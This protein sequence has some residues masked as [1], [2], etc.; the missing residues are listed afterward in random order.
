MT[1]V[2]MQAAEFATIEVAE[3][4]EAALAELIARY[5]EFEATDPGPWSEERVPAPLLAF[6]AKH[7]IEWPGTDSSRFLLKGIFEE[8][9]TLLR[10]DRMV[11]FFG[12]GFELGGKTLRSILR[13]LGAVGVGYDG[14]CDL[15]VQAKDPA[16]RAAE[17]AEFLVD[18]DYEEQF[19][20]AADPLPSRLFSVTLE[21]NGERSA[22]TFN[23]AGVQD[24]A[25][26]AALPQL[27]GEDPRLA[28]KPSN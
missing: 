19:T 4:A 25:F 17:L 12:G 7:G 23:D 6:G 18:E 15:I 5:A 20:L 3:R 22:L 2:V 26:V 28:S 8:E 21:G 14:N 16:A 27:W 9:A 11:F 1:H 24:W 13:K 10:V